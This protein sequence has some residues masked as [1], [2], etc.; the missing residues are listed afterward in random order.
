[1]GRGGGQVVN[2]LAF[3]SDNVNSNPNE[4][5]CFLFCKWLEK[6]EN[7]CKRGREWRIN[8]TCKVMF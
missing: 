1:M 6:N 8:K 3:Y 2:V 4:V 7:R 5:Y